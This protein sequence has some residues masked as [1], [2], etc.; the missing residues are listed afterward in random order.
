M[1]YLVKT[2]ELL[3]HFSLFS[4]VGIEFSFFSYSYIPMDFQ[5]NLD[6]YIY[7]YLRIWEHTRTLYIL[8]CAQRLIHYMYIYNIIV[9]Y[10]IL[11]PQTLQGYYVLSIQILTST[12]HPSLCLSLEAFQDSGF[13]VWEKMYLFWIPFQLNFIV[14]MILNFICVFYRCYLMDERITV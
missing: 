14:P 3:I 10:F 5:I 12:Q 11:Y 8:C 9:S 2:R 7:R 1:E 4:G 13:R 6:L